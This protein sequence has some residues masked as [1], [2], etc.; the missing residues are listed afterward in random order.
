MH[1]LILEVCDGNRGALCEPAL[2]E[3]LLDLPME[4]KRAVEDFI[5]AHD[6]EIV[7]PIVVTACMERDDTT[8]GFPIQEE[9]AASPR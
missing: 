5:E 2:L 7:T 1:K 8:P 6:G 9:L 3:S 4:L